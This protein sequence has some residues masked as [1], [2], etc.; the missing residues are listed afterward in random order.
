MVDTSLQD[1]DFNWFLQNYME[2]FKEY[3]KK[4]LAIKSEVVLGAYDSFAEAVNKTSET[5]EL[6]TFI[7]QLCNGEESGYTNY[8]SSMH[9]MGAI[10]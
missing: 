2:L 5:E 9:F 3:G 4:Y 1:K 6:G 7:V 8:I 10:G